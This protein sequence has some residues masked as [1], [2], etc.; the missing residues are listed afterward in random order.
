MASSSIRPSRRTREIVSR[1][2]DHLRR[3]A[4]VKRLNRRL[5]FTRLFQALNNSPDTSSDEE[6]D[7]L[8]AAFARFCRVVARC[9]LLARALEIM[10]E[11]GADPQPG[12][13]ADPG[14]D[15][16]VDPGADASS[17]V[18]PIDDL[19]AA[20]ETVVRMED[21]ETPNHVGFRILKTIIDRASEVRGGDSIGTA[22]VHMAILTCEAA[23]PIELRYESHRLSYVLDAALASAGANADVEV[24][25]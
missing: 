3:A 24:F 12:S 19:C 21:V 20:L 17:S 23:L 18:D 16:G 8:Y 7:A 14:A 15:P 4:Y 22:H 9:A 2:V 25:C 11:P 13:G 1:Y 5:K 6:L 10:P